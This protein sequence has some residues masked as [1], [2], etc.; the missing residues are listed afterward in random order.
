[1]FPIDVF[2]DSVD[3]LYITDITD[4]R[5]YRLAPGGQEVAQW[6][7]TGSERG[8]L[9]LPEGIAV[10]SHNGRVYVADTGNNRIEMFSP[11]GRLLGASSAKLSRPA[12]VAVDAS[13][14]LYVA[15]TGNSRIEKFAP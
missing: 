6:G 9:S 11:A 8:Q 14:N 12:D 1:M 10:D 5:V 4:D 15:D 13:G 7:G 3:N 2:V